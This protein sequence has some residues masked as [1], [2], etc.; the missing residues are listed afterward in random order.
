MSWT[1]RHDP[2][3][4][5]AVTSRAVRSSDTLTEKVHEIR[6]AKR[7]E[8]PSVE[9]HIQQPC[10]SEEYYMGLRP[11]NMHESRTQ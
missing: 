6:L 1:G 8:W 10:H 11:T 2:P 3:E 4:I 9:S 7:C 5:P